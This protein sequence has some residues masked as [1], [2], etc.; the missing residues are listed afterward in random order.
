MNISKNSVLLKVGALIGV[1]V[2]AWI[3]VA[4]CDPDCNLPGN[5]CFSLANSCNFPA[6]TQLC[7]D[8]YHCGIDP[9]GN[10][11]SYIYQT[12]CGTAVGGTVNT[13]SGTVNF[14]GHIFNVLS[15]WTDFGAT[16]GSQ[17]KT[18]FTNFWT[19]HGATVSNV[20]VSTQ[21]YSASPICYTKEACNCSSAYSSQRFGGYVLLQNG[22][23][24]L[25]KPVTCEQ[26]LGPNWCTATG[27][28]VSMQPGCPD[29]P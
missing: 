19:S 21:T 23:K 14:S 10:Y 27:I 18:A 11:A 17:A 20:S 4:A 24:C 1:S 28:M 9:E 7:I 15:N 25:I 12:K 2:M 29:C 3:S 13:V 26:E 6:G 22:H 5:V 16:T 8:D